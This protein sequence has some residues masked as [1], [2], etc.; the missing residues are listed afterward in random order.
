MRTRWRTKRG[1][2]ATGHE[3]TVKE[4]RSK[5]PNAAS[6][7]RETLHVRGRHDGRSLFRW[8]RTEERERRGSWLR[9]KWPTPV[10]GEAIPSRRRCG[11]CGNCEKRKETAQKPEPSEE[12]QNFARDAFFKANDTRGGQANEPTPQAS[13][14]S[15][16]ARG[17]RA[18]RL[19]ATA[20]L[21]IG[22]TYLV[23]SSTPRGQ[24]GHR[25]WMLSCGH[26]H[27]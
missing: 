26:H 18:P 20:R 6:T 10:A 16:P 13:S 22:M 23:A 8:Q 9:E 14:P 1:H 25:S 11:P 17:L 2:G 7:D 19:S 21:V 12:I 24:S 3:P 15:S 4:H 5:C 27:Q